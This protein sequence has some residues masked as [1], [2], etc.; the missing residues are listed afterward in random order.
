MDDIVHRLAMEITT[1]AFVSVAMSEMHSHKI[2]QS[3]REELQRKFNEDHT[4]EDTWWGQMQ[5]K[6]RELSIGIE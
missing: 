6:L 3:L 1:E 2:A 5:H 4:A